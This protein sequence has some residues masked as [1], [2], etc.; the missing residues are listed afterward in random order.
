MERFTREKRT[1]SQT[2]SKQSLYTHRVALFLVPLFIVAGNADV[3][4]AGLLFHLSGHWRSNVW[5]HKALRSCHE[6]T[7]RLQPILP[8]PGS[9]LLGRKEKRPLFQ[10][11]H[12]LFW[13]QWPLPVPQ[14]YFQQTSSFLLC[15]DP[16][17]DVPMLLGPLKLKTG[18]CT[19]ERELRIPGQPINSLL[20]ATTAVSS[21]IFMEKYHTLERRISHS[22]VNQWPPT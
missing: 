15:L 16:F 21:D 3:R 13:S 11:V 17:W 10:E 9:D 20:S 14:R 19:E 2:E 4:E 8:H 6:R 12:Q 1:P 7:S 5:G 22:F 18:L